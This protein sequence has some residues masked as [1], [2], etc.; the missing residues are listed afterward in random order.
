MRFNA[1]VQYVPGKQQ[2]VADVFSRKP[3]CDTDDTELAHD[4][5]AYVDAIQ[6]GWPA[7][8]GKLTEI[9]RATE[10]DEV[11][12]SVADFVIAGWPTREEAVPHTLKPYYQVRA[13][14]SI[15]DGILIYGN[16]IVIPVGMQG[17]MLNR[18]H[19]SHQH[20]SKTRERESHY[21]HLVASHK[22]GHKDYGRKL[23]SM[24]RDTTNTTRATFA[25]HS[26][27]GQT[28]GSTRSRPI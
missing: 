10:E 19:E 27:T 14:I 9:R 18:L 20:I 21:G 11:L 5:E 17:E 4:V 6:S 26:P 1:Y 13:E 28:L 22:Q 7:S 16:R 8:P 12:R 3:T 24:S 2:V 15:S 25:S 23:C